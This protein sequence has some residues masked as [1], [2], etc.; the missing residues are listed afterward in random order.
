MRLTSVASLLLLSLALVGCVD[1]FSEPGPE[2]E[3][4]RNLLTLFMPGALAKDIATIDCALS[5][6]TET[7]C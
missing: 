3:T 7:W 1:D 6:G 4:T 5:D 2:P